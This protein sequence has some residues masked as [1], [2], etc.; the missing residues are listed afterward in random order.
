MAEAAVRR[1]ADQG[2]K[3]QG[4]SLRPSTPARARGR[5]KQAFAF[6]YEGFLRAPEEGIYTLFAPEEF[7]RYA[8]LSG[9]DLDVRL[10]Y[11]NRWVNGSK[12]EVAPGSP[13]QQWYPGTR[14]HALGNWSI[15]LKEGYHP[16]EIYFADIRP[17]GI[18]RI[19]AVQVRRRQRSRG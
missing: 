15:H 17:G 19:H 2:G 18:S 1:S 8:P 3:Q 5:E 16:I 13:L 9:Y 14:R 12:A 11:E 4:R 7:I 10:G 6:R